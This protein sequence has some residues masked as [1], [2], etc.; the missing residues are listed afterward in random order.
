MNQNSTQSKPDTAEQPAD[1]GLDETICSRLEC[2]NCR[3]EFED[4]EQVDICDA[5]GE[6]FGDCDG[7]CGNPDCG[8]DHCQHCDDNIYNQSCP[9]CRETLPVHLWFGEDHTKNTGSQTKC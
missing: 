9:N 2:P 7:S 6:D 5:C 8:N 4:G 1:E 3:H